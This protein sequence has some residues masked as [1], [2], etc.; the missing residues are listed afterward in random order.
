[1][2][3]DVKIRKSR[4]QDRGPII[5]MCK[6]S[7]QETYG[8]FLEL[9]RVKP[10]IEGEE[11]D[12]YVDQMLANM[13]VAEAAGAVVGV[14]ALKDHVIDL[15]WVAEPMRG[16]G[17]GTLLMEAAEG[18]LAAAGYL[19]GALE[20]FTPNTNA[21]EF[22]EGRG[23]KVADR[24]ADSVAGVEKVLMQKTLVSS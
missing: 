11:T 10:W 20:C 19:R 21:I 8:P 1:M 12:H 9:D 4:P 13:L 5:H 14:T 15:L 7:L 18:Q 17:I 16:A 24:Y 3:A 2:G 6:I 22:Y 23:W